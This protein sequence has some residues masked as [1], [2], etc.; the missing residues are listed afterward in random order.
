MATKKEQAR[1]AARCVAGAVEDGTGAAWFRLSKYE[2][3]ARAFL[4][5]TGARMVV[6]L[7]DEAARPDWEDRAGWYHCQFGARIVTARGSMTV[8]RFWG[9]AK[10]WTDGR[11]VVGVYEILAAI[12]KE[13]PG[14]FDD[15]AAEMGFFPIESAADYKRVRAAW[16]GCCHEAAGV[17]RCWTAS[18]ISTLET[19]N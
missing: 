6:R 18:E 16:R 8:P 4:A 14:A 5:A 3:R 15:F 17:A 7:D 12:Q 2:R 1:R 13:N 11:R 19:I 10:D 9:S